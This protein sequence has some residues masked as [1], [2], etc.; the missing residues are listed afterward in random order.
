MFIS[1]VAF[2]IA[3]LSQFPL[4]ILFSLFCVVSIVHII[5]IVTTGFTVAASVTVSMVVVLFPHR[6][7]LLSFAFLSRFPVYVACRLRLSCT[8]LL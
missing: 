3:A 8:W 7:A 2:I 4:L 6:E 5:I 1:V